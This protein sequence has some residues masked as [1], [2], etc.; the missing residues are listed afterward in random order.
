MKSSSHLRLIL[1]LVVSA[2][3][4]ATDFSLLAQAP[5]AAQAADQHSKLLEIPEPDLSNIGPSIEKQIE[6]AQNALP[7]LLAEPV[8]LRSGSGIS[9]SLGC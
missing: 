7:R 9:R 8:L 4:L 2:V 3:H 6:A 1:L 5:Q